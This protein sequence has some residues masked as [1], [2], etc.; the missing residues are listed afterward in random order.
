MDVDHVRRL[1]LDL[2]E[3]GERLSW[4]EPAWFHRRLVARMWDAHRLTVHVEDDGE[5]R[6][7][8][9]ED[10]AVYSTTD[11]HRGTDLLL[12]DL[13]VADGALVGSL[14]RESWW[15]AAP[16]VLRRRHPGLGPPAGGPG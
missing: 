8:A 7:L 4:G 13:R 5:R 9:A 11:H 1:A 6:A 15:W 10:P 3:V 16:A 2:P 14:L 12:V